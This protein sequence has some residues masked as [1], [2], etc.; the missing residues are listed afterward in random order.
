MIPFSPHKAGFMPTAVSSGN[1]FT[2]TFPDLTGPKHPSA[3]RS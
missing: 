2:I 3:D 1:G